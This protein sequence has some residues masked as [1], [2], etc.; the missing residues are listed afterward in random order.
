MRRTGGSCWR[1]CTGGSAVRAEGG[2]WG[3]SGVENRQNRR[4]GRGGVGKGRLWD[5]AAEEVKVLAGLSGWLPGWGD[6]G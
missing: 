5:G 6:G 2:A 4:V 1:G 3:G